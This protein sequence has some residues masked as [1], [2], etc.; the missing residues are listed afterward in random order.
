MLEDA[1]TSANYERPLRWS[2]GLESGAPD[3]PLRIEGGIHCG[4]VV[5]LGSVP[6]NR[7]SGLGTEVAG[8]DFEIECT[9]A[10]FA[11]DTLEPYSLFDPIGGVVSHA[12]I[13]VLCSD[14][15]THHGELSKVIC[16]GLVGLIDIGETSPERSAPPVMTFTGPGC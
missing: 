8:L 5:C 14:G 15:S 4:L 1:A 9:D 3:N 11:P 16:G 2:G 6:I 12:L 13:L 7:G 10:V